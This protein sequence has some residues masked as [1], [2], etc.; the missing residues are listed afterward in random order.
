MY[1]HIHKK[2][3]ATMLRM[4]HY[5]YC[6][7]FRAGSYADAQQIDDY[8]VEYARQE[9]SLSILI[10]NPKEP[11]V[12]IVLYDN[13]STASLIWVG[14]DSKCTVQGN[15]PRG[16]GTQTMIDFAFGLAKKHGAT[17][18]ELMDDAKIICDGKKIELA[19]MYFLQYGVTWYES[20]FGF[21]PNSDYISEYQ[22][23]KE[24]R[25]Q[26]LDIPFLRQQKCEYFTRDTVRS[27]LR[28]ID[29]DKDVFYKTSW[30][31]T[32]SIK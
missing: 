25:S 1:S 31:K 2:V 20:K 3:S 23:M 26:S 21:Q 14:Y 10:W 18:I 29:G 9:D 15:M 11:C 4:G 8:K 13:D 7:S 24:N 27:L 6:K 17:H 12:H 5:E 32:L 28:K 22:R 16:T 19:P 30:I